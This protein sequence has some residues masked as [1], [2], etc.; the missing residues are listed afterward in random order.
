MLV[1]DFALP[2]QPRAF[3]I[4]RVEAGRQALLVDRY[5]RAQT[6][7]PILPGGGLQFPVPAGAFEVQILDA[8][9]QLLRTAVWQHLSGD[10]NHAV[11]PWA[12]GK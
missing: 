12:R 10:R 1:A 5:T 4:G 2:A 3:V 9:G 6:L 11:D 8:Q 7:L